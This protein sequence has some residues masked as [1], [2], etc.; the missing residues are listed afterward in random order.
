MN[1]VI[2]VSFPSKSFKESLQDTKLTT[3]ANLSV[4]KLKLLE[5]CINNEAHKTTESTTDFVLN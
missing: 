1:F 4:A 3:W 2:S 5:I